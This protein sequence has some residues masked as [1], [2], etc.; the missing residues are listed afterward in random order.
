M[1]H[2]EQLVWAALFAAALQNEK[3]E[4][5][6]RRKHPLFG[7]QEMNVYRTYKERAE[8]AALNATTQLE[9]LRE[10][11]T[12]LNGDDKDEDAAKVLEA[13]FEMGIGR[14]KP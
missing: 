14:G 12:A 9:A 1:T 11:R 6:I 13:L 8:A 3:P 5:T 2:G 10:L 4:R 7:A